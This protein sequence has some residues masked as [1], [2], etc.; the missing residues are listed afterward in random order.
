MTYYL[1]LLLMV[2]GI[3]GFFLYGPLGAFLGL[4]LGTLLNISTEL[5]EL[6][7]TSFNS[8]EP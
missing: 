7:V 1:F 6:N 4:I 5:R 8:K 3:L 2:G